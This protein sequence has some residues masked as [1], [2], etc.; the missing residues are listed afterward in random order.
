M[1]DALIDKGQVTVYDNLSSGKLE[2]IQE[3]L[4]KPNLQ[5]IE[6]DCGDLEPI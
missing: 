4:D 3:H 2:F 5:F 6:G 1:V